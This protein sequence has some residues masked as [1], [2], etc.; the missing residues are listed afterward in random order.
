MMLGG[1]LCLIVNMIK[2][3][4]AKEVIQ[5]APVSYGAEAR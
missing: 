4:R 3:A 1:L 5:D 2:T